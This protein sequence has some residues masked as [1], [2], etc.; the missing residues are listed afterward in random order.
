MEIKRNNVD[1]TGNEL[2]VISE[3]KSEGEGAFKID[4]CFT[5]NAESSWINLITSKILNG[6]PKKVTMDFLSDGA[7]HRCF[8]M[9]TDNIGQD[10]RIAVPGRLK[11]TT[12]FVQCIMDLDK[13]YFSYPLTIDSISIMLGYTEP[14]GSINQGTIIIDNLKV[15]YADKTGI[16]ADNE[17]STLTDFMLHQNYPNPFNPTTKIKYVISQPDV[18][19]TYCI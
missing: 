10:Y 19:S 18:Y 9:L 16:I 14:I 1:Q 5:R 13:D 3:P 7:G 6:V 12:D 2:S 15:D 17:I 4:Y 11:D 8:L